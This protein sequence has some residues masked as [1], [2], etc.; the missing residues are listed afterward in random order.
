MLRRISRITLGELIFGVC[1]LGIVWTWAVYGIAI[2]DVER[3]AWSQDEGE[4]APGEAPGTGQGD[5]GQPKILK[6]ELTLSEPSDLKVKAGDQVKAG[7]V[8]SDRT[9]I[10]EQLLGQ[11]ARLTIAI[12]G[13][14]SRKI[15]DPPAPL[16]VPP[17]A[18]LPEANYQEQ[19]RA[20]EAAS[21]KVDLQER[22]LDSLNSGSQIVPGVVTEH[23][24]IV[25]ENLREELAQAEAALAQ[26][27]SD[28]AQQEYEHSL[29]A[30]RRQEEQNQATLSYSYQVQQ[31]AQQRRDQEFQ[32]AQLEEKLRGV[33]NELATLGA[34]VAPYAG[35]VRRVKW[36][37]QKDNALQVEVT[38]AA[39]R[40]NADPF[41]NAS[42]SPEPTPS[43]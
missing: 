35:Q 37:G 8:L 6:F 34:V 19:E 2:L 41:S 7:D 36:L 31:V 43:P 16:P 42:P 14:G 1:T 18:P 15:A 39:N 30:A 21:R 22:K 26:A 32:V 13:I 33:E 11:K 5:S 10:R 27:Q 3:P 17:M 38:I 28:R 4:E 23:E 12:E 9:R 40:S 29:N 20:I 24:Q 25:L